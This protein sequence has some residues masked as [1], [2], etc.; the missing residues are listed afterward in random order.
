M[1]S[2]SIYTPYFYII[3]DKNTKKKYAGCRWAK[4]CNPSEFMTY[5]GYTTSS[6][7]VNS[8]I[9]E[10]GID[11]FE[12]LTIKTLIEID[13][14]NVFDY[15]TRWLVDHNC[16]ESKEWYNQHN[17]KNFFSSIVITEDLKKSR[18]INRLIWLSDK[19]NKDLAISNLRK[20]YDSEAT[21]LRMSG[22][23]NHMFGKT[24]SEEKWKEIKESLKGRDVWNSGLTKED[25]EHIKASSERMKKKNPIHMMSKEDK[26]AMCKKKAKG[27]IGKRWFHDPI[28][29]KRIFVFPELAPDNYKRGMKLTS[30]LN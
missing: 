27:Q 26:S 1:N 11:S 13:L 20:G 17:N 10:F 24:H 29:K 4:G 23:N 2:K 18:S 14:D 5:G 30:P 16:K 3:Q 19:S 6:K 7:I 12:I 25:S 22:E 21:S 15:E 28:T 8:I 9:D